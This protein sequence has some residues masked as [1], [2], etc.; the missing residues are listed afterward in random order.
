[1]QDLRQEYFNTVSGGNDSINSQVA[2]ACKGMPD[3]ATVTITTTVSGTG[4]VGVGSRTDS[5]TATV[6]VNC[7]DF[8]NQSSGSAPPSG[9]GK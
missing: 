6:E 7:G 5:Y 4:N 3:S 9:T 2:G 1:M 8:N